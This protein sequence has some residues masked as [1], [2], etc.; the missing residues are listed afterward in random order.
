M[1][2]S[3]LRLALLVS[4]LFNL[5]VLGALGWQQLADRTSASDTPLLVRE[6]QLDDEQQQQWQDIETLFLKELEHSTLAIQQQRNRLID[7]I[8]AQQLDAERISAAQRALAE[9]QNQQQQLVIEQLLRER[10]I[11]NT[12]QRQRLAQ[13]LSQQSLLPTDVEMLHNE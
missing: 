1:N 10:E 11:L 4:V 6:L 5:G 12:A 3:S 9:Q 7:S 2:T 13:L 8:F